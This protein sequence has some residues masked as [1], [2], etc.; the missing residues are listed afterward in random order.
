ML[1]TR[2]SLVYLAD[3]TVRDSGW[4]EYTEW[5]GERGLLPPRE[6]GR[7]KFVPTERVDDELRRRVAS[8]TLRRRA[9]PEV[10]V[11]R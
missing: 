9:L 4:L 1:E 3:V 2:D 6:C 7:V 5:S 10:G 8:E 11:S